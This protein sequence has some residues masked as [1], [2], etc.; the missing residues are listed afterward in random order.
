MKVAVGGKIGNSHDGWAVA[1]HSLK[2][3][4]KEPG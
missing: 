1:P 4:A 3:G 2:A